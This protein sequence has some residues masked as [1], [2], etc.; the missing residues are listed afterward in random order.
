MLMRSLKYFRETKILSVEFFGVSIVMQIGERN[1][2][3]L[4]IKTFIDFY[5]LYISDIIN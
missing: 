5:F 3:P 2:E 1:S 4:F